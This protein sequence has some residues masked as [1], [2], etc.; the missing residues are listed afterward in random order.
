MQWASISEAAHANYDNPSLIFI[1]TGGLLTAPFLK[2]QATLVILENGS[3]LNLQSQLEVVTFLSKNTQC[4]FLQNLNVY[5]KEMFHGGG[6]FD[7]I[8]RTEEEVIGNPFLKCNS[9]WPFMFSGGIVSSFG[10]PEGPPVLKGQGKYVLNYVNGSVC[11]ASGS[12]LDLVGGGVRGPVGA[13]RHSASVVF[14]CQRDRYPG[15][16]VHNPA[17][18]SRYSFQMPMYSSLPNSAPRV[19]LGPVMEVPPSVGF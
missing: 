1:L 15:S 8:N 5:S 2:L 3:V 6:S 16:P 7:V 4:A 18:S 19:L 10:V 12:H 14:T 17:S 11:N 9:S 13:T